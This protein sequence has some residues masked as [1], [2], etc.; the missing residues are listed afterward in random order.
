MTNHNGKSASPGRTSIACAIYTRKSTEEGLEKEFNSLDAQRESAE[1]YVASQRH[2]GWSCLPDR[3]DDG[4]YTGGNMDRPAL[5]RLLADI[6]AGKVQVVVVYKVDRLSRSLLDFAKMIGTFDEYHVSFVSVTQQFNTATSMGRL[7]LNVLLS[8]AQFEREII[9]ERTRDK[10]AAARRKGKWSGGRPVLG[11]DVDPHGSKLMVNP[12]EDAQVRTIFALYLEHRG[13]IPVVQELER[14]GWVNK[15]WI[16]RK[17]QARGGRAFTKTSLHQLLT[18]VTYIGKVK[19]KNEVHA[20]EHMAIV[21]EDVWQAVQSTL[22]GNRAAARPTVP[23]RYGAFLKGL[24]RCT[25]CACAM[26]PSYAARR[27]TKYY[28]YYVCGNAQKRGWSACPSKALPAGEIERFVVERIADIAKNT[29]L[30][31]AALDH[32]AAD[33]E[34][35]VVPGAAPIDPARSRR[36]SPCIEDPATLG[37]AL[38]D[39]GSVWNTLPSDEQTRFVALV[40]E[41]VDYDGD[42]GKLAISFHPAGILQLAEELTDLR[43]GTKP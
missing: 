29:S 41:R 5:A 43:E 13:L 24:L 6:Q 27:K 35:G 26:T 16:T 2:E 9:S 31:Q 4:G 30:L 22:R 28:R 38:S 21:D 7:V 8:F 37:Q 40:V 10:I 1:A 23:N 14:R 42:K 18:N 36:A 17:G 20:G 11:Y 25:P 3:Y 15:R 19:Y 39:F 32:A 34:P 33:R 12:A